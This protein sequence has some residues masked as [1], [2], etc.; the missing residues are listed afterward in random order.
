MSINL[1]GPPRDRL[2]WVMGI[3]LACLTFVNLL[4][5]NSAASRI[6]FSTIPL[7]TFVIGLFK[8]W[9]SLTRIKSTVIALGLVYTAIVISC[10]FS[11][12]RE[13]SFETFGRQHLWYGLLFLTVAVWA[14][15]RVKQDFLVSAFVLSV[16][17]SALAGIILFYF[18]EPLEK[19]GVIEKASDYVFQAQD[20]SGNIYYRAEGLLMSYTRSAMVF[21]LAVP[22][23]ISL[24]WRSMKEKK[25]GWVV[26]LALVLVF[27]V[28]YLA[29]TKSRGAWVACLGGSILILLMHRVKWYA[30]L[31]PVLVL[32]P[33]SFLSPSVRNRAMTM[34]E[35]RSDPNL[36]F[37]RRFE[38][39]E[40]G[41]KAISENP[42]T[43]VGFGGN[44]FLK[45]D[46]AD[47][48]PLMTDRPQPDLHNFYLQTLAEVGILGFLAYLFFFI[49]LIYHGFIIVKDQSLMEACPG[50]APVLAGVLSLLFIGIVYYMNEE[51]VAHN[52]WLLMGIIPASIGQ[53]KISE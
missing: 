7:F 10:A 22:M 24:L 25:H 5:N 38:L 37:S 48:Y 32:I 50:A 33:V 53:K 16:G 31:L 17:V 51:H 21:I 40:Q 20:E 4:E 13:Y 2:F 35:H 46:A 9:F 19:L 6:L 14:T 52:W 3:S 39:W 42:V 23:A 11:L 47:V 49:L 26:L 44:I 29:L 1:E 15:D 34:I 36:L 12:D 18:A 41:W 8:G 45:S 30:V 43:G 27:S 28:Y